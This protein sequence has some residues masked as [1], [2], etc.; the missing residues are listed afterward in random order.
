MA[1]TLTLTQ[2]PQPPLPPPHPMSRAIAL[3]RETG[4]DTVPTATS[5]CLMSMKAGTLLMEDA[6][7]IKTTLLNMIVLV[8]IL[9]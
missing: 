9:I 6:K 3:M 8:D 7:G 4:R 5:L 1:P 2:V